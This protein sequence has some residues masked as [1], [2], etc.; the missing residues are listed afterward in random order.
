M[1]ARTF[2]PLLTAL[3]IFGA[4]CQGPTLGTGDREP[5]LSGEQE[6][7]QATLRRLADEARSL[8]RTD[9]CTASADCDALPMGAKPCG[10]PWTY[11]PYCRL[12]TNRPALVAKLDELA[13]FERQFNERY[14]LGSTCDVAMKPEVRAEGGQ[15]VADGRGA[16]Y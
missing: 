1:R 11:L 12:T 3:L 15:C 4:A 5:R 8:A 6:A 2:G 10:G 16:P 7:D 14:G 9:G 13:R